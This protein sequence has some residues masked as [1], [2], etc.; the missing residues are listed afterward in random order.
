MAGDTNQIRPY[1]YENQ[2]PLGTPQG[3]NYYLSVDLADKTLDWLKRA[4]AIQPDKPWFVYFAPAAT[5]SPH[6]APKELI[7]KF[8]GQFDMGWDEYR[9]QTFACQRDSASYR[10]MRC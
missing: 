1:L 5:H 10:K 4:Q 6:Q 2:T 8:K 3:D 9:N 7:D